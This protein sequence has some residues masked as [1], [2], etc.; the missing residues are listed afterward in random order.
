[1]EKVRTIIFHPNILLNERVAA[2]AELSCNIAVNEMYNKFEVL[3]FLKRHYSRQR[4]KALARSIPAKPCPDMQKYLERDEIDLMVLYYD[5]ED[6]TLFDYIARHR[7]DLPIYLIGA[8]AKP[9]KLFE[10]VN[11][12]GHSDIDDKVAVNVA[13]NLTK[14]GSLKVRPLKKQD[15]YRIK[16]SLVLKVSPIIA[17]I[18]FRAGGEKFVP[19]YTKGQKLKRDPVTRLN[20]ERKTQ[21]LYM[22]KIHRADAIKKFQ[23][24]MEVMLHQGKAIGR[25]AQNNLTEI[26][27]EA[28]ELVQELLLDLGFDRKTQE[29]HEGLGCPGDP[30][31]TLLRGLLS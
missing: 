29:T 11:L 17:D 8:P 24:D 16:T 28:N 12:V 23:G 22:H 19:T 5:G 21:Y 25:R 10:K 30:R 13:V 3:P 26:A 7:V 1:M 2:I 6:T 27:S 14:V 18:F 20:L 9:D 31:Q 15:F 4:L